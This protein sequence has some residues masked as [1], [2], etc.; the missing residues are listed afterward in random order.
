MD[1]LLETYYVILPII[2]SAL[3]G[4]VVWVLQNN[5]KNEEKRLLAEKKRLEED[6]KKRQANIHGTCVILLYMLERLYTEYKMQNF[7]TKEQRDKFYDI[8]QVYHD[9]GGNGYGTALCRS[10]DGLEIRNDVETISPYA[11]LLKEEY[12]RERD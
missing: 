12:T 8:Y 11:K 5:K 10:I 2:V 1:F 6:D 9:L 7:I 4:Y 3:M